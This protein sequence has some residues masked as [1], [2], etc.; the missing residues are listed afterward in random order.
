MAIPTLLRQTDYAG[1][2]FTDKAQGTFEVLKDALVDK[3]GWTLLF[4]DLASPNKSFVVANT[5]SQSCL[6]IT[7]EEGDTSYLKFEAAQS[8]SDISTPVNT[9]QSCYYYFGNAP[10]FNIVGDSKRFYFIWTNLNEPYQTGSKS[11]TLFCGDIL[12]FTENDPDVFYLTTSYSSNAPRYSSVKNTSYQGILG[13]SGVLDAAKEDRTSLIDV[14][15]VSDVKCTILAPGAIASKYSFSPL[16]N[17]SPIILSACYIVSQNE[18]NGFFKDY[19]R[20]P[21]LYYFNSYSERLMLSAMDSTELL[22]NLQCLPIPHTTVNR[23]N[24]GV[25]LLND[26][27]VL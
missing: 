21:G 27:D 8:Y 12:P 4:E 26:W 2:D 11:Y 20:M 18:V 16:N 5:G 13:D 3:F 25:I 14:Y 24:K 19:G 22:N 1:V 15:N 6:K 23:C 10:F 17:Q 9:I 7:K